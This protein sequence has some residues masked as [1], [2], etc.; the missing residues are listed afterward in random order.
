MSDFTAKA[1]SSG[2]VKRQIEQGVMTIRGPYAES[3]VVFASDID[4]KP[5]LIIGFLNLAQAALQLFRDNHGPIQ[6]VTPEQAKWWLKFGDKTKPVG[7]LPHDGGAMNN[8]FDTVNDTMYQLRKDDEGKLLLD[9]VSMEDITEGGEFLELDAMVIQRRKLEQR[10]KLLAAIMTRAGGELSVASYQVSEPFKQR[11]TTNIVALFELSDGQTVSVYFHNPDTTPN[12][13]LPD[14]ELVSWKWLLNKLDITILVAREQGLDLVPREVA[15]RVMAL[16]N[17]NSQ[18]FQAANA[19]RAERLQG[20]A[21]LKEQVLQSERQV[22][23]LE[24]ELARL[25]AMPDF[26][27]VAEPEPELVEVVP[28]VAPAVESELVATETAPNPYEESV[29]FLAGVIAGDFDETDADGSVGQ[30]LQAIA[31]TEGVALAEQLSEAVEAYLS[32]LNQIAEQLTGEIE[33]EA[34]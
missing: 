28:E 13:I 20:I 16:A 1:L 34:A 11:G 30:R 29:Q 8:W 21:N 18:K 25:K 31:E 26:V 15:R 32:R 9:S 27:P 4:K 12:K 5:V 14:D 2:A 3:G 33:L 10:I 6:A 17:R 19:K 24:A 23:E 22:S 7:N